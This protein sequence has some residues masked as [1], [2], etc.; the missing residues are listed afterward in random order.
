MQNFSKIVFIDEENTRLGP[1]TAALFKKKARAAGLDKYDILSR[2]TVVLFPEPVNQ[3][4]IEIAK[5]Y[6][7]D[8][9]P[10]S[11]I[12]VAEKDFGNENLVLSLDN[13]SK[14]KVYDKFPSA[15]NVYTLKEYLGS[16][17]D[18][19][20]PLGGTIEEFQTVM[21]IVDGLLDS[22]IKKIQGEE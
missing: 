17:G 21:N 15:V 3:K 16:S 20:P 2:G 10:Y 4:I 5:N 18:I 9:T 11:A 14:K 22:L 19:K 6:D 7:I 1:L 8:L 13:A 12:A